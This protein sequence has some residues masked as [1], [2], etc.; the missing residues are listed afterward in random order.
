M[1][2][3]KWVKVVLLAIL[4]FLF[5]AIVDAVEQHFGLHPR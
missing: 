2:L 3:G 1:T 4:V 5:I